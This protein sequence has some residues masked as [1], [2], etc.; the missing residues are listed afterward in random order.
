MAIDRKD[1]EHRWTEIEQAIEKLNDRSGLRRRNRDL[2][3]KVREYERLD[4]DADRSRPSEDRVARPAR[5][6]E[7][8]L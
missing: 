1:R 4:E 5:D 2:E 7:P 8:T 3:E 6:N